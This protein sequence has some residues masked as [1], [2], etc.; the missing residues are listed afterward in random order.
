M[1]PHR[2]R[3]RCWGL[4]RTSVSAGVVVDDQDG[5]YVRKSEDD[6]PGSTVAPERPR[7]SKLSAAGQL[8]STR[9]REGTRSCCRPRR[10]RQL[11]LV[12]ERA[13]GDSR[14]RSEHS[15]VLQVPRPSP[16]AQNQSDDR[17]ADD[18]RCSP[19]FRQRSRAGRYLAE[20][21]RLW[22]QRSAG[23]RGL[24]LRGWRKNVGRLSHVN[25]A[26]GFLGVRRRRRDSASS[27]PEQLGPLS[28]VEVTRSRLGRE[29]ESWCQTLH[30]ERR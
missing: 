19:V 7:A 26:V 1:A 2:K 4:V 9:Q 8:L 14:R 10:R 12:D 6:L 27:T 21:R 5:P 23:D 15:T 22:L 28:C 17:I 18:H 30:L 11:L 25:P 20:D 13:R 24:G 29:S 3:V 16:A